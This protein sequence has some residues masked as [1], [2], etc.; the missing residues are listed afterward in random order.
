MCGVNER[1]Y[2]ILARK[3]AE[4]RLLGRY[5]HKWEGNIEMDDSETGYIY[6]KLG[7]NGRLL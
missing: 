2:N 5:K 7:Y 1:V 4:K 3:P 6:L